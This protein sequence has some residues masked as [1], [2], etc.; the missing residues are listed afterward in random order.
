MPLA[1]LSV[2][3]L[4]SFL[5]KKTFKM[6]T[7]KVVVASELLYLTFISKYFLSIDCAYVGLYL[8]LKGPFFFWDE[9][10]L[11]FVP[12]VFFS[13]PLTFRCLTGILIIRIHLMANIS[14][15]VSI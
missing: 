12:S 4:G 14:L 15:K 13:D 8:P 2:R 11:S 7:M 9:F 10:E 3:L 6:K 1:P 5:K